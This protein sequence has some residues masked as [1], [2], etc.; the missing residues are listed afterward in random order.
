[1]ATYFGGETLA[2]VE[3]LEGTTT[4]PSVLIYTVPSGRYALVRANVFNAIGAV[5]IGTSTSESSGIPL[6][7]ANLA[8]VFS[9]YLLCEGQT[10]EATSL[11]AP[12]NW[13]IIVREYSLP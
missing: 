4:S 1:M 7:T 11:G 9:D 2:F 3:K 6:S 12:I 5:K 10:I 8:N 13:Y